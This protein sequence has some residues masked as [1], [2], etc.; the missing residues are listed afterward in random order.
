MF[1][2]HSFCYQGL[3]HEKEKYILYDI[4]PSENDTSLC[5]LLCFMS[6][7]FQLS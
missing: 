3:K 5:M 1:E 6:D 2:T 7:T 4:E